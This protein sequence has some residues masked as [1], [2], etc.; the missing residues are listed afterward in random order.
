MSAFYILTTLLQCNPYYCRV[1]SERSVQRI[2]K[3]YHLKRYGSDVTPHI[4]YYFKHAY[5]G[6]N[7]D[8]RY[9]Y[10]NLRVKP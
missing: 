6:N 7:L 3:K 8:K 4:H 9:F 1:N 10:S 5:I 2:M